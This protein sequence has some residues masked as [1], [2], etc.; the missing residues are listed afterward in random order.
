LD[1]DRTDPDG[2]SNPGG[3]AR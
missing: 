2:D 3:D 1:R